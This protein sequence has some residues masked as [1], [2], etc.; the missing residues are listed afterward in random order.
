MEKVPHFQCFIEVVNDRLF[1][2]NDM[3]GGCVKIAV[4][5]ENVYL[6]DCLELVLL[7]E[8]AWTTTGLFII[9]FFF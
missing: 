2:A 7:G 9:I 6:C 8:V 3:V 1:F 5:D 4:S